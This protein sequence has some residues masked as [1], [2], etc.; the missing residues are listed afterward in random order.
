MISYMRDVKRLPDGA[1][2]PVTYVTNPRQLY[3]RHGLQASIYQVPKAP[4]PASASFTGLIMLCTSILKRN[5][6]AERSDV[7]PIRD[8]QL[9]YRNPGGDAW[10]FHIGATSPLLHLSSLDP[11]RENEEACVLSAHNGFDDA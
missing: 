3:A 9:P 10:A 7:L 11:F 6:Q 1:T 4:D 8:S 2:P 5:A